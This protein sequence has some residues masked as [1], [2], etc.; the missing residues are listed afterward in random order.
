VK[1]R[2]A[3]AVTRRAAANAKAISGTLAAANNGVVQQTTHN[4]WQALLPPTNIVNGI[5]DVAHR[6]LA[7][8]HRRALTSSGLLSSSGVKRRI[9]ARTA[10]SCHGIRSMAADM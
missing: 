5:S 9:M 3:Y 10:A 1:S 4:K 2:I 7:A 8:R 6:R